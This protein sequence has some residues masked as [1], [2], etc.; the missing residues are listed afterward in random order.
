[1]SPT[2]KTR[3][4]AQHHR[5]TIRSRHRP[6][7]RFRPPCA[8][9]TTSGWILK[10]SIPAP[11]NT[12]PLTKDLTEAAQGAKPSPVHVNTLAQDLAST[13]AGNKRLHP[14]HQKLAQFVHALFNSSHLSP[15]QQQ[16]V[17]DSVKKILTDGG[18]PADDVAKVI[19]DLKA[20]ATETK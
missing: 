19:T 8:T 12:L 9:S 11:T 1:M 13:L 17:L 3:K 15:A 18:V 20:I 4:Q 14:Q 2:V 5:N 16:T 10:T 7:L 6:T